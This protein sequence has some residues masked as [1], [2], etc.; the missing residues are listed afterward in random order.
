MSKWAQKIR[1]Y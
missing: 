1:R